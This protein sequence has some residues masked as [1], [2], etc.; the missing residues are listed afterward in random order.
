MSAYT[1][2]V[3]IIIKVKSTSWPL[4]GVTWSLLTVYDELSGRFPLAQM[5]QALV[6]LHREIQGAC[7]ISKTLLCC[8]QGAVSM[9]SDDDT[10]IHA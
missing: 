3:V 7:S 2:L 4:D 5:L 9:V 10:Y 8:F 1:L 6:N